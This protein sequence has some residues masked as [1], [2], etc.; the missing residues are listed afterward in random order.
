MV[1]TALSLLALSSS[2]L[3]SS[4]QRGSCTLSLL[5]SGRRGWG[6]ETNDGADAFGR[7]VAPSSPGRHSRRF[8]PHAPPVAH[9]KKKKKKKLRLEWR[10]PR[11]VPKHGQPSMDAINR[12]TNKKEEGSIKDANLYCLAT[13]L[14]LARFICSGRERSKK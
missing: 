5:G 14:N 12:E 3:G 13:P 2:P 10:A 11:Q 8:V 1:D 4:W 9:K 6:N 7:A